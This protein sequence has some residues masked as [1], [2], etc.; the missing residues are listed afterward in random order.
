[1]LK[2]VTGIFLNVAKV[3][4]VRPGIQISTER[5]SGAIIALQSSRKN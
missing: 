4:E 5:R 1:M 2:N 3:L